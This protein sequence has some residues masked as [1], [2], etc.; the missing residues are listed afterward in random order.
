[1]IVYNLV[2]I[3]V[4]SIF[5]LTISLALFNAKG[6][7][8]NGG[9]ADVTVLIN[10]ESVNP[11]SKLRY[12]VKRLKEKANG[13]FVQI[14]NKD[15]KNTYLLGLSNNRLSELAYVITHDQVEHLEV[16]SS[17]YV[18]S[19]GLLSEQLT[20]NDNNN[21]IEASNSL[22]KHI[23]VLSKLKEK[24]ND[25]TAEWRFTQQAFESAEVLLSDTFN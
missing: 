4:F 1:M 14:F 13:F 22:E 6:V 21:L 12:K 9:H 10:F 19:I 25:T 18:T 15:N 3:F 24:Y 7:Y 8:A 5:L 23:P 20:N 17:R 11:D 2:K 16:S